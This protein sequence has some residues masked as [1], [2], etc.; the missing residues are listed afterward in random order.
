MPDDHVVS[1]LVDLVDFLVLSEDFCLWPSSL[2][3]WVSCACL[4]LP[5]DPNNIVVRLN[6]T[7]TNEI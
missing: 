5:V 1:S 7:H 2:C 6:M 4:V 3:R